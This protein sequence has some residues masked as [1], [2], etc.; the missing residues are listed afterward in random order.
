MYVH[1]RQNVLVIMVV[2]F[3][4]YR[5]IFIHAI[6]VY[7]LKNSW[8]CSVVMLKYVHNRYNYVVTN[9]FDYINSIVT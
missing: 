5:F 6:N 1:T 4:L 8:F 3:V 7:Q 2:V 9:K